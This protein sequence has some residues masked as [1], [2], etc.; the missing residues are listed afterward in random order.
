MADDLH[1][2]DEWF[3][4]ILAGMAPAERRRA[5]MKLGH[6]LRRSNLARIA[7]N[8][9]PDGAPFEARKP[10]YSRRGRLRAKQPGKMFRGLRY[11]KHWRIDAGD[12]G[13]EIAADSPLV[14]RMAALHHFGEV[15]TV[16]RLRNGTPIRTR[17]PER[18]LLGFSEEDRQLALQ[19]AAE[20]LGAQ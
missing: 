7:A 12:D 13:V 17:Y 5:A 3:G 16:G 2:L 18:R 6:A 14:N 8:V 10:R 19:I 1:L 4:Q 9:D 11:A 20:L 15:A